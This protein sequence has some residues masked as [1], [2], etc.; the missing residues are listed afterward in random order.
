MPIGTT[1]KSNRFNFVSPHH[2][3]EDCKALMIDSNRLNHEGISVIIVHIFLSRY[4]N[5]ITSQLRRLISNQIWDQTEYGF[6]GQ[7]DMLERKKQ[8]GEQCLSSWNQF[9]TP[10]F[11]QIHFT[12]WTNTFYNLDKCILQFGR[13]EWLSLVKP[14]HQWHRLPAKKSFIIFLPSCSAEPFEPT[15]QCPHK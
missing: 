4:L 5:T 10:D 11:L 12:N 6:K 3:T 15:L 8:E 7:A 13:G 2:F 9:I 14:I 1:R